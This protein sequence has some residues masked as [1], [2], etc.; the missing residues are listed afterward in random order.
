MAHPDDLWYAAKTTRVVYSPPKL[1]ETF[2]ETVVRYYVLSELLDEVGAVRIR[3]G[4]VMAGR[5]RVIT[6]RFF[7]NQALVNFG[8]EARSYLENFISSQENLRIIEY[9]LQFR[10]EDHSQETVQGNI[11]EIAEQVTVDAKKLTND[12]AGVV[13]GVDDHWEVSLLQFASELVKRSTPHNAKQMAGRG[14]LDLS[15]GTPNAVRVEIES[16]FH[17]AENDI[18]RLRTLGEKLRSYGLFDQYEDRFF[19]LYRRAKG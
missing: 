3:Q 12:V 15:S 9:G 8:E 7:M 18:D 17:Q 11:D 13:I 16:D 14:L 5:P 10:K 2:G 1:L 4:H 6:P 19:E